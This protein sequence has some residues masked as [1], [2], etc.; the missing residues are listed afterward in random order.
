MRVLL[1]SVGLSPQIV[2][3]ALF[4]LH[5]QGWRPDRL[6]I[7]TTP[8]GATACRNLLLGQQG[9]LARYRAG[10]DGT[11]PDAEMTIIPSDSGDMDAGRALSNMADGAN[12]LV[13]AICADPASELCLLLSGGRKPA[14][15]YLALILALHGRAQDRLLHVLTRPDMVRVPGFWFPAPMRLEMPFGE[16]LD[17]SSVEVNLIDIPFPR[18]GHLLGEGSGFAETIASLSPP[19][20]ARLRFDKGVWW[21]GKPLPM[22]PSLAAWLH[23]LAAEAPRGIPRVGARRDD[24]LRH[25]RHYAGIGSVRAAKARLSDPLDPEWIEEKAARLAKLGAACGMAPRNGSLIRRE[26]D[27]GRARYHLCLDPEDIDL[28]QGTAS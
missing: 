6:L 4:A 25:Y 3:E 5:R 8:D 28:G 10:V 14:A 19:A 23:W 21:Q 22:Q 26:G 27:P 7:L 18:L 9:G 20:L 13:A 24:Y 1:C 11:V 15:A 16:A 17:A 2:T 12:R